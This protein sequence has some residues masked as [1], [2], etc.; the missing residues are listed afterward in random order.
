MKIQAEI[1]IF[2]DP[3]KCGDCKQLDDEKGPWT[4]GW[5]RQYLEDD[6]QSNPIKCD[7]CKTARQK[8]II[9]DIGMVKKTLLK[10]ADRKPNYI[11]A[12]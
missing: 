2:D 9:K 4:C 7:Q 6:E 10:L 8:A 11:E 3:E 1:D 5:T 12:K